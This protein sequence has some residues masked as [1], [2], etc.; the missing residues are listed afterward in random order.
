M[1]KVGDKS[2][3]TKTVSRAGIADQPITGTMLDAA[4][5]RVV[6]RI[7]NQFAHEVNRAMEKMR[8]ERI[9]FMQAVMQAMSAAM[10]DE[11][12]S[13]PRPVL[14]KN[15][16]IRITASVDRADSIPEIGLAL[17]GPTYVA[18]LDRTGAHWPIESVSAADPRCMRVDRDE[19][20]THMLVVPPGHATATAR[21]VV[22][23]RGAGTPFILPLS[24]SQGTSRSVVPLILD[25]AVPASRHEAAPSERAGTETPL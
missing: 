18:F 13:T 22:Q 9:R 6:D 16:D 7:E 15:E 20:E 17:D 19:S 1:T 12:Q 23:L 10:G 8:E 11:S 3:K 5:N 14:K 2:V 21:L 25:A 24:V 4:I